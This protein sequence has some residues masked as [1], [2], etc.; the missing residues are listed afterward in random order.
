MRKKSSEQTLLVKRT[1]V[2]I[3]FVPY[4]LWVTTVTTVTPLDFVSCR[5]FCSV[6]VVTSSVMYYSTHARRN[7]I[8]LLNIGKR[9]KSRS[10]VKF[11]KIALF[12]QGKE[13]SFCFSKIKSFPT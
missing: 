3:E 2:G 13:K 8:Y 5:T 11:G 7:V 10:R 4:E 9:L 6:H 1:F 12:G